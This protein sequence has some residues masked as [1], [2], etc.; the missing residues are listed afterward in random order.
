MDCKIKQQAKSGTH[1][2]TYKYSKAVFL[3]IVSLYI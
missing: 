2:I 1:T 3:K